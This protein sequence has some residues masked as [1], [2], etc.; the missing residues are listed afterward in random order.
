MS[1]TLH[2]MKSQGGNLDH[3]APL[4]VKSSVSSLLSCLA[5]WPVSTSF[6]L[7]N[8]QA[9]LQLHLLKKV[10]SSQY[11]K[12]QVWAFFSLYNPPAVFQ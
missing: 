7:E 10:A 2:K 9:Q 8:A 12:D 5:H 4:K 1:M 6:P 3:Q 11:R